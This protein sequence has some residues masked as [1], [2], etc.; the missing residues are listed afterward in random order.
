MY[1]HKINLVLINLTLYLL[2]CCNK[3][4]IA[5]PM[6]LPIFGSL[7]HSAGGWPA[8]FYFTAILNLLWT[9]NWAWIGADS[10]TTH[11]TISSEEKIYIETSLLNCKD[12][13]RVSFILNKLF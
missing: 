10:P 9:I 5:A 6:A 12:F 3:G 2:N 8:I 4:A 1:F 11:K 7:A 13:G